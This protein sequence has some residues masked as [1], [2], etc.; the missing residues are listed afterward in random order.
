MSGK[1]LQDRHIKVD[2]PNPPKAS[3]NLAEKLTKADCSV[4]IKAP[5]GCNTI[6]IKNLPYDVNEESIQEYFK[7]FGPI[8]TVRLARWGHTNQL[9]GFGYVSFKRPDSAEI[10]VKKSKLS[11]EVSMNGREIYCDFETGAP[12]LS[13]QRQTIKQKHSS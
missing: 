10:A 13:F 7:V 5:P 1:Y 2:R 8:T 9:K 6:F 12:K 11:G 3:A 4:E